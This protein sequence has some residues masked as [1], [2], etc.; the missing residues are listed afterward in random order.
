[1]NEFKKSKLINNL[2]TARGQLD[3]IIRMVEEDRHCIEISKQILAIQSI[4]KKSNIK[5]I[6][7]HTLEHIEEYTFLKADNDRLEEIFYIIEKYAK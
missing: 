1:M 4:L 5:L 6:H 2:K 7:Q 3:A